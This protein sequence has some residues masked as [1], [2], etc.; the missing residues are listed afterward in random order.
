MPLL[1]QLAIE[2]RAISLGVG[3]DSA[4]R[5]RRE[6][7]FG[8]PPLQDPAER[9]GDDVVVV[10][11]VETDDLVRHGGP[12][13][14]HAARMNGHAL[15]AHQIGQRALIEKIDLDLVVLIGARHLLRLPDFAGKAV[16]LEI[17]PPAI[18]MV[19]NFGCRIMTSV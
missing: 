10:D 6:Q 9:H 15:P 5:Q 2:R 17:P 4:L 12:K 18:K 13:R 11:V 7:V 8:N 14:R 1:E 16:R 19:Q 3:H